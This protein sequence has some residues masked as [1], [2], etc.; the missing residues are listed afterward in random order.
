IDVMGAFLWLLTVSPLR[1]DPIIAWQTLLF[2]IIIMGGIG[3]AMKIMPETSL[4]GQE[5]L[6][7]Y[8]EAKAKQMEEAQA[9]GREH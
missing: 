8:R 2:V 6:R 3:V 5:T 7:A 9:P 4:S 1:L